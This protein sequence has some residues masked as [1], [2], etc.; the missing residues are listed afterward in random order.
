MIERCVQSGLGRELE[1][2]I[3]CNAVKV[4]ELLRSYHVRLTGA[5]NVSEDMEDQSIDKLA[6]RREGRLLLEESEFRKARR[7]QTRSSLSNLSVCCSTVK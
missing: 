6:L 4:H 2:A 3:R 5:H 1:V 7:T